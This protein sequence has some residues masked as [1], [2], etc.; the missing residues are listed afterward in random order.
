MIRD[1]IEQRGLEQ[2]QTGVKPAAKRH[3]QRGIIVFD[4]DFSELFAV[5]CQYGEIRGGI[6]GNSK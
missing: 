3:F 2:P 6:E 4:Q 5:L 1:R